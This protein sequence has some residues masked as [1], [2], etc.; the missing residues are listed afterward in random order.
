MAI[1]YTA[2]GSAGDH[3]NRR[4]SRHANMSITNKSALEAPKYTLSQDFVPSPGFRRSLISSLFFRK[5]E[6]AS[7][8]CKGKRCVKDSLPVIE[9]SSSHEYYGY[10]E[11]RSTDG[12]HS[13]TVFSINHTSTAHRLA[14]SNQTNPKSDKSLVLTTKKSK[15]KYSWI[16][17]WG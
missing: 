16:I 9:C 1:S 13:F 4:P 15:E 6:T 2:K 14:R 3:L 5:N 11:Y 17:W 7:Q 8:H 10:D 12:A